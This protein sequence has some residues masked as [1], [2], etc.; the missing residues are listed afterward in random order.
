MTIILQRKLLL[1][2]NASSDVMLSAEDKI[3]TIMILILPVTLELTFW[4]NLGYACYL[5]KEN[6]CFQNC[7][8]TLSCQHEIAVSNL[9]TFARLGAHKLE[10]IR[11]P[12][13]QRYLKNWILQALIFFNSIRIIIHQHHSVFILHFFLYDPISWEKP[14]WY[15]S[16]LCLRLIIAFAQN[17]GLYTFCLIRIHLSCSQQFPYP[18]FL[19][20]VF[21]LGMKQRQLLL[22][23]A[24][25]IY[26]LFLN[27]K[28]ECCS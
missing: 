23:Y 16:F 3:A 25:D 24:K 17:Q 10:H 5:Y 26:N 6:G 11:L 15:F 4:R 14:K 20:W 9:A 18:G 19:H 1:S 22:L 7:F 28:P 13:F 2:G 12:G 21:F 8:G 27:Q